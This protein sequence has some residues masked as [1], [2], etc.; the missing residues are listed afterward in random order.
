[1][2]VAILG[3]GFAGLSTAYYLIHHSK[4][5]VVIDLFDP[6]PIGGGTSG[7]SAG[8]LHPFHGRKAERVWNADT[9]LK[10]THTLITES[11]KGMGRPVVTSRGLLRPAT[12]PLQIAN[13]KKAASLNTDTEWWEREK[14]LNDP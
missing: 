1:M 2:R 3:A 6:H 14:C 10:A 11:S 12:T 7:L 8:L 5:R 9:L 4:G 13:Y